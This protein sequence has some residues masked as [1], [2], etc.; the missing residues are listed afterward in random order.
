[1]SRKGYAWFSILF[2]LALSAFLV[3][4]GR[5]TL[6]PGGLP[7]SMEHLAAATILF[8]SFLTWC[9]VRSN[10]RNPA[11]IDY[12]SLFVSIAVLLVS[13]SLTVGGLSKA[14]SQPTNPP[15]SPNSSQK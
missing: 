10:R 7:T 6:P 5:G 3:F 13:I 14:S 1:M 8:F 11:R 9:I 12:P 15:A 4:I 2:P